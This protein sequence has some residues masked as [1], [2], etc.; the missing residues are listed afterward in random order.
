MSGYVR[1]C[2]IFII[3]AL[4][5]SA[6]VADNTKHDTI[7]SQSEYI[8]LLDTRIKSWFDD[9]NNSFGQILALLDKEGLLIKKTYGSN[10]LVYAFLLHKKGV[11]YDNLG[12][13]SE[14]NYKQAID[15]YQKALS[16]RK[17]ITDVPDS[18]VIPSVILGYSNIGLCY[19]WLQNPYEA[20]GYILKGIQVANDFPEKRLI[21][22][23]YMKLYLVAARI[24]YDIGDYDNAL[25]Y[26]SFIIHYQVDRGD[27]EQKKIL[28]RWRILALI[29]KGDMQAWPLNLPEMAI[30]DLNDGIHE[31]QKNKNTE[32]DYLLINAYHKLG[33]A[34]N[35]VNDYRQSSSYYKKSIAA[36]SQYNTYENVFDS[37][38]NL[39][40]L[41]IENNKL[42][43]A[44]IFLRKA[45]TYVDEFSTPDIWFDIYDNLGDLEYKK[46][47]YIKSV[48]YDNKALQCIIPDFKPSRIYDQPVLTDVA[49]PD[50]PRLLYSLS[51]KANTLLRLAC[52]D[53]STETLEDA[54][55]TYLLADYVIGLMRSGFQ[56]DASK[57]N[58][59]MMAKPVYEKAIETCWLLYNKTQSD[60]CFTQAFRFS[61]KSRSIIL[62]DA[63]RKTTAKSKLPESIIR[64][65]K[66]LNLKVNYFEKQ[67]ALNNLDESVSSLSV[68]FYDSL[69]IYRRKHEQII[70]SIKTSYPDYHAAIYEQN[71]SS[72]DEV[73]SFL[74]PGQTFI[75]YFVGD[76]NLYAFA[77][78]QNNKG[79]IRIAAKDSL[80]YWVN[81]FSGNIRLKD[82]QFILPGYKLYTCLIKSVEKKVPLDT[83][84]ILVPDDI[85]SSISFDALVTSKPENKRIYFPSFKDYLI[86]KHQIN[87]VFSA[88]ALLET[89]DKSAIK[90][91]PFLGV[92]PEF[93]RSIK[94]DNTN[95]DIL[96]E[97]Q[98][99]VKQLKRQFTGSKM[100]KS[101][102][103][104]SVFIN[105]APKYG[106]IHLATHAK[107]NN[108]DGDLSYI[109]FSPDEEGK[110]YAKDLYALNLNSEMVVLSACQTGSGSIA[111]GEGTISLARGFIYAGSSS[112]ITSLWNVREKTNTAIMKE[113]YK[114]IKEGK[115]KD[116]ALRNAKLKYLETITRDNQEKAHPFYWASLV[117]IGDSSSY[118]P[119]VTFPWIII[120]CILFVFGSI[121]FILYRRRS[122]T[123][124]R[125]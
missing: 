23:T 43:S 117:C 98:R 86:Y 93:A 55:K 99:E 50:K 122:T 92:A 69:L 76:S 58:L 109:L 47:N 24:Y 52:I 62:L 65:E 41:Y 9:E 32:N 46:G 82:Q 112:V 81:T 125:S 102:N 63:V 68:N 110:L 116:E 8:E 21:L 78:N 10:S 48:E 113:F 97:N 12:E 15:Y 36:S 108:E 4:I 72:P 60:S 121:G 38:I 94:I 31:L 89:H 20:I 59:V 49:I 17:K 90:L 19:Y 16:I 3:F 45:K 103:A 34:Y 37:Y 61:E 105:D 74:E 88:T 25:K 79:F 123:I 124:K 80:K 118:K 115:T 106:I 40:A 104:R 57:M 42:D 13:P 5:S 77:I 101:D 114:G 85:L 44:E 35:S 27:S 96:E 119:S 22:N 14:E 53:N 84:L 67:V 95:F 51:S 70:N 7:H 73:K 1:V 87:Y 6:F 26:Y 18:L 39:C 120:P 11:V 56:A 30:S 83:K 66:E 91:K 29:E 71:V 107:A 100:L 64:N 33:L 75:E 54:Y 28:T 111:R 2:I